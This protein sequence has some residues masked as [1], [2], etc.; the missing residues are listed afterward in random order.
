MGQLNK[1]KSLVLELILCF[2]LDFWQCDFKKIIFQL[3]IWH[4]LKL[5]IKKK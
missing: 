5:F 1:I 2:F 3:Y 4:I